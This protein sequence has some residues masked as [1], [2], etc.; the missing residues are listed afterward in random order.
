[1]DVVGRIRN[2]KIPGTVS[3]V[4]KFP[5]IKEKAYV[6]SGA[7]LFLIFVFT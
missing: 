5:V 4:F 6:T 2:G 7:N 1:M 3:G